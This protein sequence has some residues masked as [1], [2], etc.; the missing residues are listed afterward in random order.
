M[1]FW[2]APHKVPVLSFN[3]GWPRTEIAIPAPEPKLSEHNAELNALI[4]KVDSDLSALSHDDL[5]IA[6]PRAALKTKLWASA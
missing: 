6:K 1:S 2:S 5:K 3:P 4:K